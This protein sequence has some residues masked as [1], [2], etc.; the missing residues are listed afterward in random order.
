MDSIKVGSKVRY[1]SEDDTQ[2]NLIAIEHYVSDL[3]DTWLCVRPQSYSATG[4]CTMYNCFTEDLELGWNIKLRGDLNVDNRMKAE[5]ILI[6]NISDDLKLSEIFDVYKDD[7]QHDYSQ[8]YYAILAWK[9][10]HR[11]ELR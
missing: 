2:I 3:F 7:L 11:K 6:S 4:Q 1:K 9:D 8:L 10:L 5:K